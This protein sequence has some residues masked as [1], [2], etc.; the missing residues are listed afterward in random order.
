MEFGPD[1]NDR[2]DTGEPTSPDG[3]AEKADIGPMTADTAEPETPETTASRMA[4]EVLARSGL[5]QPDY[6]SVIPAS[7]TEPPEPVS[8]PVAVV[9]ERNEQSGAELKPVEIIT[10][11]DI[12]CVPSG[13]TSGIFFKENDKATRRL[14]LDNPRYMD[15]VRAEH[16]ELGE[17]PSDQEQELIAMAQEAL[18]SYAN[19]LGVDVTDR[20]LPPKQYRFSDQLSEF[21]ATSS[22]PTA[23]ARAR[24]GVGVYAYRNAFPEG[25]KEQ[26]RM[27]THETTHTIHAVAAYIRMEGTRCR[28]GIIRA[29]YSARDETGNNRL[30]LIE[31]VTDFTTHRALGRQRYRQLSGDYPR[32]GRLGYAVALLSGIITKYAGEHGTDPDIIAD[33]VVKGAL[34][35]DNSPMLRIIRPFGDD[36]YRLVRLKENEEPGHIVRIAKDLDIPCA[37]L[38]FRGPSVGLDLFR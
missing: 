7:E 5:E 33:E 37:N 11:A 3:Y 29:P 12:R 35:G 1:Y 17:P 36:K 19:D 22:R 4:Q 23:I 6:G 10:I 30:G 2:G 14:A 16:R 9:T 18:S 8:E 38:T 24:P 25:S 32:L 21:Q 15:G 13:I 20:M 27:I 28:Y 26:L 31:T 34:V